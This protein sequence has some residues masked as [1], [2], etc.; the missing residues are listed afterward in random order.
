MEVRKDFAKRVAALSSSTPREAIANLLSAL[1]PRVPAKTRA[2]Q[3]PLDH[4]EKD[5]PRSLT[6]LTADEILAKRA[7]EPVRSGERQPDPFGKLTKRAPRTRRSFNTYEVLDQIAMRH[8]KRNTW[9]YAMVE[10]IVSSS[11]VAGAMSHL[12]T[13]YPEHAHKSLDFTWAA[14]RGYIRL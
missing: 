12:R 9:T 13:N 11:S 3:H 14:E 8:H 1:L 2:P 10:S 6:G 4:D 7:M 5:E